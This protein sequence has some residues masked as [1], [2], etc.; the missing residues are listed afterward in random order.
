[1]VRIGAPGSCNN[2]TSK[3]ILGVLKEI[4]L[5]LRNT[6]VHE[7]TV[8]T[9][10]VNERCADGARRIKVKNRAFHATKITNVVKTCTRGKR[11]LIT[12]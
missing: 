1:M 8:V 6:T 11:N 12:V 7:I 9:S 5:F 10:G 4:K 2:G 3:G